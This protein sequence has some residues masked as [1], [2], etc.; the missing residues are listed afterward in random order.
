M[1]PTLLLLNVW[2]HL[3]KP[4][5]KALLNQ[6]GMRH[7]DLLTEPKKT[8]LIGTPSVAYANLDS[9][10]GACIVALTADTTLGGLQIAV[11]GVASTNIHWMAVVTTTKVG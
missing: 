2:L 8:A 10:T 11:T 3:F 9:A 6:I 4:R 5:L 7:M 1:K